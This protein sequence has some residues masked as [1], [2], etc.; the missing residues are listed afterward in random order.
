VK[1]AL[2]PYMLRD[3]PL[4]ELPALV[5]DLGYDYIEP[6]TCPTVRPGA[7]PLTAACR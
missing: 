2:G 6:R 3:V 1:I 5:A 4:L 7:W